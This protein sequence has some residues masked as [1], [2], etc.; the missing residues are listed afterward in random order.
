MTLLKFS[1]NPDQQLH[2]TKRLYAANDRMLQVLSFFAAALLI[3][4]IGFVATT[5]P[6]HIF[7]IYSMLLLL[8][9]LGY[10]LR[11]YSKSFLPRSPNLIIGTIL[12]LFLFLV[13]LANFGTVLLDIEP[14]AIMPL[15]GRS[16]LLATFIIEL[17]QL[18]L[19]VSHVKVHPALVFILSFLLL[20]FV[21]TGM[22]LLPAATS[23]GISFI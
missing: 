12:T 7:Y 21:G 14:H 17:S 11:I 20:I 19:R 5:Q 13:A 2:I 1:R 6:G 15:L 22:L 10:S 8:L 18:S 16:L 23:Q 9:G 4:D 3:Y